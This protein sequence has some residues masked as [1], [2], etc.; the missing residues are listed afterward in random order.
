[1]KIGKWFL[2]AVTLA[3]CA[4]ALL[5][6]GVGEV[7]RGVR[8]GADI[9][10]DEFAE[11]VRAG[12]ISEIDGRRL[13]AWAKET[14]EAAGRLE[15]VSVNWKSLTGAQK[16][17]AVAAFISDTAEAQSR[18]E[19]AGAPVFKSERARAAY[20]EVQKSLRRATYVLREF[21]PPEAVP[22]PTTAR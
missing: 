21:A 18:L 16:R 17:A 14:G 6:C 22:G 5:A 3:I 8:V 4:T 10:R 20:S 11:D 7:A 9:A 2:M 12:E 13:D 1:M 19:A 15:A